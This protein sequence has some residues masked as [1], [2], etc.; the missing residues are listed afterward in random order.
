MG[1]VNDQ[2]TLRTE[3]FP[4]EQRKWIATLLAPLNSFLT[5]VTQ[6]INGNLTFGENVPCQDI[7]LVFTYGS[8]SDFP[9]LAKWDLASKNLRPK[10]LRLCSATENGTAIA[11]VHSWYYDNGSVKITGIFKVTSSGIAS[12]TSGAQY[13]IV[14]RGQP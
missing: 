11:V 2:S 6:A 13:N 5:D 1:L 9:K 7:A 10:E 3:D 14:F 8:A 12:L 4:P